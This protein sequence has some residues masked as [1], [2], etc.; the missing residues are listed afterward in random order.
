MNIIK[1]Y[2]THIIKKIKVMKSETGTLV[3]VTDVSILKD[4]DLYDKLYMSV[5][6]T[7]KEKVDKLRFKKDKYL[8]LGAEYLLMR[9]CAQFGIDYYKQTIITNEYLKPVFEDL[10]IGFNLS[11]S[12]SKAM[13][14]MS[15]RPV[16]CDIEHV[17]DINI[18]IARRYFSTEEYQLLNGCDNEEKRKEMFF[19]LWTLKESFMKCMGLGFRLP[20]NCFSIGVDKAINTVSQSVDEH[21]YKLYEENI[22][23]E[24]KCSWCIRDNDETNGKREFKYIQVEM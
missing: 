11:H 24:Y 17:R 4:D 13:C 16:G 3:L 6:G 21:T 18:K 14:I 20:L 15:D 9:A 2:D 23:D 22:G 7:R 5:S 12:G 10:D 8:S 1:S 19:R